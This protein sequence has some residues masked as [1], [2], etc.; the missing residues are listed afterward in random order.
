MGWTKQNRVWFAHGLNY[1]MKVLITGGCGYVGYSLLQH[2]LPSNSID[3][4]VLYDNLYRSNPNFFLG[5]KM[6]NASK[7]TLVQGDILDNFTLEKSIEKVDIVIHLAAKASTP[8]ADSNSHEFDQVNNW[9]TSNVAMAIEKSKKVK[10]II[11][12]SSISVYGNTKGEIVDENS[13]TAP[14]S[15]YGISKL[16][17]ERHINRLSNKVDTYIFRAGNIFGYNPSMRVDAVVNKLMFDAQ[18]KKKI[19]V[20]GSGEQK[21][22]FSSVNCISKYLSMVCIKPILKPNLYNLVNFNLSINDVVSEIK[23]IY[24]EIELI[25]LDQHL[26]MRSITAKSI[27]QIDYADCSKEFKYNLLDIKNKFSF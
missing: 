10:K 26:E 15:F 25:F 22:A 13:V 5:Q 23:S 7:I 24:P 1:K 16:K 27:Y 3:E 17:G 4:I 6:I 8:F 2:L 21:R 20:H 12:L 11:Y 18:Y 9:G 19:E 14:K